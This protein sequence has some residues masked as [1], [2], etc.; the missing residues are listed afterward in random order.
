MLNGAVAIIFGVAIAKSAL[1]SKW[2][3]A[4]GIAAGVV[5]LAAGLVV[6]HTLDSPQFETP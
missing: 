1:L 5:T 6:A 4:V 3:G 2:I